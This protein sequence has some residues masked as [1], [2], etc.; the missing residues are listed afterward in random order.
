V[1]GGN[2][3]F[4]DTALRLASLPNSLWSIGADATLP[5]FE[6]GLRRAQLLHARSQ[7]S[8]T[9]DNYRATVLAA[10]QDVEDGLSHRD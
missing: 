7:Y 8:Q 2:A 1:F 10:F 4:E 3:G 5:L 6:G 9:R